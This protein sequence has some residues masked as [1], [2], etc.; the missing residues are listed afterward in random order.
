[1]GDGT[2]T[3]RAYVDGVL[4]AERTVTV[5]TLGLGDFPRG[6]SGTFVLQNFPKPGDQ[7]AH[8]VESGTPELC[9]RGQQECV[10]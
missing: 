6:L 10:Q 2:H 3:V 9:H 1:M 7:Y 5:T 4:L 8:R